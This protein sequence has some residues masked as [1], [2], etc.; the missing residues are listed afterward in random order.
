MKTY[1]FSVG[2][3]TATGLSEA[4]VRIC[5]ISCYPI[6]AR[7]PTAYDLEGLT[8]HLAAEHGVNVTVTESSEG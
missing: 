7:V 6:G 5:V 2:S 1:N 8:A 3:K 4:A